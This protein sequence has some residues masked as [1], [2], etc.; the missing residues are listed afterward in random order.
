MYLSYARLCSTTM[1]AVSRPG[2]VI[3]SEANSSRRF[4]SLSAEE[5]M[6]EE[7]MNDSLNAAIGHEEAE[8]RGGLWSSGYNLSRTGCIHRSFRS[9]G[10]I[11]AAA[12]GGEGGA[13]MAERTTGEEGGWIK[14][15]MLSH[16]FQQRHIP[17]SLAEAHVCLSRGAHLV[18]LSSWAFI[19]RRPL[20]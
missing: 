20:S 6:K 2:L 5:R 13:V 19:M 16:G 9:V 8:S 7:R 18:G 17:G 11:T 3:V 1:T 14:R 4:A 12:D 15:L 10:P